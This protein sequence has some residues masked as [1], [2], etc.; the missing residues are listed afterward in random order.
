MNSSSKKY[1]AI[2]D[3]PK[4]LRHF[5]ACAA[6]VVTSFT[7]AYAQ[8]VYTLRELPTP[9]GYDSAAPY[10]INDQGFIVGCASN[11]NPNSMV[12]TVWRNGTVSV[13]G[14]LDKGTYSIANAINSKGVIVGEGDDGDGRPLG[15]ITSGSKLVNFFSN[16]GGNTHPI[17]INDN[18]DVGGYYI[19]F[20]SSWRGAIWKVDP[21]DARKSTKIDLPLLIGND[22]LQASATPF[23]F[24]KS[25]QAAGWVG[26]EVIGQHAALWNNDAAHSLVDLGTYPGDW[27]SIANSLNDFGQVV[28][29]S[30]PPA[31]SR[32]VMWNNDPAHTVIELPLLP[33]DNYGT[34][35]FINNQGTIIGSSSYNQRE[36]WTW[37]PQHTRIVIWIDG[38][39]FD[40]ESLLDGT[41]TGWTLQTVMGMNNLGQLVGLAS[42]NGDVGHA[43]VLSRVQ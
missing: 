22:P 35:S 32:P 8:P 37:S 18:G 20:S 4:A 1:D 28:G 42:H 23:A 13:L 14:K 40:L 29:E 41:G 19:K 26:N 31:N 11:P 5:A 36:P 43:V 38:E 33:G 12:A 30:Y 15:W 34:A 6:I 9:A 17:A 25:M 39:V 27:T 7:A 2:M 24:N 3:C 10:S 16:N 21:K